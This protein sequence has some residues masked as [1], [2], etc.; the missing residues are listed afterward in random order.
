MKKNKLIIFALILS[1]SIQSCKKEQVELPAPIVNQPENITTLKLQLTDSAN[2]AAVINAQYRDADGPGGNA[3]TIDSL[4]LDK[5]KT[6]LVNLILQDE[7]KS[8]VVDISSEVLEEGKEHQFFYST[9]I[10]G[11]TFSYNDV[12]V[13]GNPIGLKFKL[14][15]ANATATGKTKVTLK[16]QPGVKVSAPGDITK[17]DTDVEVEFNTRIK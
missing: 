10:S 2:S 17:G 12:D 7:T 5:G 11:I 15:T 9:T 1:A 4:I 14:R 3:A 6:Y 8:P 16:H 13:N